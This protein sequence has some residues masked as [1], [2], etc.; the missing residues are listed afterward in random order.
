[1]GKQMGMTIESIRNDS[2]LTEE[3]GYV[4]TRHYVNY[5]WRTNKFYSL[6]NEFTEEDMVQELFCKFL[7]KGLFK[8]FDKKT[9]SKKYFIMRS[10]QNSL[11]DFLRKY[12]GTLSLDREVEEDVTYGEL[13]EDMNVDVESEAIFSAD[14]DYHENERL[15][16]LN[17]LP[18]ETTSK[19]VGYSELLERQ[20]NLSYRMLAVHLEAG[21]TVTRLAK[22]YKNPTTG[23]SI[24]A[25]NVS[26][27]ISN[28]REWMLDNVVLA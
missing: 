22:M 13:I 24:T 2:E 19:V 21:Y 4:L 12:R 18:D 3:E 8:K 26:K 27:H 6:K 5:F 9:T 23:K 10:V 20:V 17:A 15:R 25:G 16:I 28:M 1:M 11:I 7:T 14:S